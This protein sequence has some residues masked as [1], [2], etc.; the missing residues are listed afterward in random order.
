MIMTDDVKEKLE[1]V[2]PKKQAVVLTEVFVRFQ[3]GLVQAGDFNELKGIVKE[4][5]EAQKRTEVK[6]EE[7][8]E[9][10]KKLTVEVKGLAQAQKELAEEQKKLTVEVKGLAEAQKELAQ[11]QKGTEKSLLMFH[12]SFD[13]KIGAIGARWGIMAEESFRN[14]IEGILLEV[15]FKAERFIT[16]DEE[17]MVF[18]YPETIELDI[19][20]QNGKLF[21]VEVKSSVGK[22]DVYIYEKK[23]NFY[24][25]LTGKD[26]HRKIIVSPYVE[27]A[28]I[29]IAK[30][31]GIEVFTDINEVR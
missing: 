31:L 24:K 17:G 9:E 11:A 10:Q 18:G 25:K 30:K 4:L 1:K 26:V 20:I 28:S 15:G 13:Y 16:K 19:V 14:G 8:A 12:R 21:V 29:G 6:V 7:L 23:V 5:A 22:S 2:F 3:D 27:P